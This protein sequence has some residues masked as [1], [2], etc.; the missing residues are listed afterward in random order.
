ML[1]AI[2]AVGSLYL[3]GR[4]VW[5]SHIVANFNN[6]LA[7]GDVTHFLIEAFLNTRSIV[8]VLCV[9]LAF[10]FIWIVR[11]LLRS[12]PAVRFA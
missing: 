2:L 6:V 7:H 1:A 5:M 8:Q 10:S 4:N 3:I 12:I 11:D 9:A